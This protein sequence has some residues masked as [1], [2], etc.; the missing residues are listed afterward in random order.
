MEWRLAL[1]ESKEQK[2]GNEALS[3]F[4]CE[5][6]SEVKL[7]YSYFFSNISTSSQI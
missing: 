2:Q 3:S 5:T 7:K 6:M 4:P 1:F